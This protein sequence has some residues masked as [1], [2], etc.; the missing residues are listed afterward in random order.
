MMRA[1][2]TH[3]GA[4]IGLSP[5][6]PEL[7]SQVN[8]FAKFEADKDHMAYT[9]RRPFHDSLQMAVTRRTAT[10]ASNFAV[11]GCGSQPHSSHA[12]CSITA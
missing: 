4:L 6:D 2:A 1:A 12:L 8:D 11:Q 7:G 5:G 10:F 9:H 3:C